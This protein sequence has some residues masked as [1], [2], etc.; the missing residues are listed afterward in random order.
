MEI[1]NSKMSD[2]RT[3]EKTIV[4]NVRKEKWYGNI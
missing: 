3:N 4:K 2:M 1:I